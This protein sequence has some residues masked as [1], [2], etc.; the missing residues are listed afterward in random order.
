M[1]DPEAGAEETEPCRMAP[2]ARPC[3]KSLQPEAHVWRWAQKTGLR[4]QGLPGGLTPRLPSDILIS[5]KAQSLNFLIYFLK[6][7]V[8]SVRK[9]HTDFHFA[10]FVSI[11]YLCLVQCQIVLWDLWRKEPWKF[12]PHFLLPKGN[13]CQIFQLIIFT[14]ARV[15]LKNLH[16]LLLQSRGLSADSP[17]SPVYTHVHFLSNKF[18]I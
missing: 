8:L 11:L 10:W 9:L 4:A 13:H 2:R 15:S 1:E 7:K 5:G 3:Q 17:P 6:T 18:P 16:T 14:L 12:L